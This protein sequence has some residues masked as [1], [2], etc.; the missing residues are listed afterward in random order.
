MHKTGL[1]YELNCK[2]IDATLSV[3]ARHSCDWL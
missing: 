2:N 3:C 1:H